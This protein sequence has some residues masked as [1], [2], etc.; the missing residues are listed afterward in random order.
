M[1]Y[2]VGHRRGLDPALL[3]LWCRPAARAPIRPLAWELPYAMEDKKTKQTNKQKK[4]TRD[5][6]VFFLLE[7]YYVFFPYGFPEPCCKVNFQF[8]HPL[9][10]NSVCVLG[11]WEWGEG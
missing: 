5:V 10:G 8:I 3:W 6:H 2:G 1:S 7:M 9:S 11:G 4:P